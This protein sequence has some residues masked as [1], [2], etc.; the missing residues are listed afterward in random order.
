MLAAALASLLMV[1]APQQAVPPP[2]QD[3]ASPVVD[4][5]D[6]VVDGRRVEDL[7]Q[8]F[9]RE[10][11]AP[12]QR[13]G[14]A[15]WRDGVCVGVVNLQ[16]EMAQYIAD[17]VS[18][19]AEDV[20][21]KAGEPGCQP[22]VLVIA[23]VDSTAFT[24]QFVA[25]R[26][27]IFRVGGSGM[28]LGSGGLRKF[29]SVDRPVR[30]WNVSMPVDSDTG[31]RAVRLPGDSN[32]KGEPTAPIIYRGAASRLTTQ[33]VDDT[34]RAF[35]IVD[36]D[37][38]QD[39]SLEQLADYIAF[40]SLAQVDPDADTSGYATILNVFDDPQQTHTLTDWDKA[41]LQ[42]LYDTIRTRQN[43]GAQRTEVVD[44]I[45]RAHRA[46]TAASDAAADD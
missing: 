18:T 2:A 20:G 27:R 10:V 37:R 6:I 36:V 8:D 23:T 1:S 4:L 25:Q 5:G 39:V 26:P 15:R 14:L 31:R 3:P 38:I 7:T 45:V 19:V 44:S 29:T 35:V 28:D 34:Q 42:G 12:A 9:V 30:W 32:A 13:R 24:T 33:V 16:P 43:F 46:L 11:A 17:R 22:S 41:Y 40:V 21:L